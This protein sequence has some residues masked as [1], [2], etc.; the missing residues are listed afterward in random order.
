MHD[1]GCRRPGGE[2]SAAKPQVDRFIDR[3]RGAFSAGS[4]PLIGTA[5]ETSWDQDLVEQ[6]LPECDFAGMLRDGLVAYSG[7]GELRGSTRLAAPSGNCGQT[8]EG[9]VNDVLA[10]PIAADRQR[11]AERGGRL[12]EFVEEQPR[13]ALVASQVEHKPG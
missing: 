2:A 4:V 9:L 13:E 10:A 11:L 6:T 7:S 1:L 5:C 8:D 12:V 3:Q